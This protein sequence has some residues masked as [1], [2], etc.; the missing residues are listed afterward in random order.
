MASRFSGRNRDNCIVVA[1]SDQTLKF[2]K[3][4]PHGP[5]MPYGKM[6]SLP[7]KSQSER[8]SLDKE[9]GVIR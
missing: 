2:H 7:A 5:V 4:W 8:D 1:A 9:D 3:I 6:I